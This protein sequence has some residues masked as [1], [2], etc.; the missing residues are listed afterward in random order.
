MRNRLFDHK[1]LIKDILTEDE[2]RQ[3]EF[4]NMNP[5][6]KRAVR[7]VLLLPVYYQGVLQKGKEPNP[8]WNFALQ[9]ANSDPKLTD[10]QV[11]RFTRVQADAINQV[12]IAF[13]RIGE[14]IEE[15]KRSEE[16]VNEA[17]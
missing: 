16:Q 8:I 5:V 14:F 13:D 1:E 10:E 6:M 11:G 17:I 2:L 4:F 15:P 3:L 12:E 9:F 7:K